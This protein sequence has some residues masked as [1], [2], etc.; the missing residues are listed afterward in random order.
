MN[1]LFDGLLDRA[2]SEQNTDYLTGMVNRR[3][4]YEIWHVLPEGASVHC[5]YMDVDN[6]KLVND[7]YG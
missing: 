6:F 2:Q 5:F 7:V 1:C 3:G 4:M